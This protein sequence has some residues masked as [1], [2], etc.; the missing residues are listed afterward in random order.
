MMHVAFPTWSTP[1]LKE[2]ALWPA[3][4][5]SPRKGWTKERHQ[6]QLRFL[7]RLRL[8]PEREAVEI[9]WAI[10]VA[11]NERP[12][13]APPRVIKMTLAEYDV[14]A[15]PGWLRRH[16][17]L[18]RP[19]DAKGKVIDRDTIK[20]HLRAYHR[21]KQTEKQRQRRAAKRQQDGRKPQPQTRADAILQVLSAP[22]HSRRGRWG[23]NLKYIG[24]RV[25]WMPPFHMPNGKA[26]TGRSLIKAIT[27][28]IRKPDVADKIDE[29]KIKNQFGLPELEIR[30]REVSRAGTTL[31]ESH[32]K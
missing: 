18:I 10:H 4:R 5:S 32:P 25:G 12:F 6:R 8:G 30:L 24:R 3:P 16:P 13:D 28:L 19:V 27:R 1:R 17:N 14:L 2:I 7:W 22:P 9:D 26:L 23:D 11:T 15:Q 21:P 20:Q 29:R 31:S